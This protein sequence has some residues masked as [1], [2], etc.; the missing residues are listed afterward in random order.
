[1][2]QV[3]LDMMLLL[4]VIAIAVDIVCPHAMRI[5]DVELFL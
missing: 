3:V 2:G 4:I 5:D 1:M